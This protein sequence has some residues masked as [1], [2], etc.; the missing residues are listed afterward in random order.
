MLD[1]TDTFR[2]TNKGAAALPYDED[3]GTSSSL[4]WF[5][6]GEEEST[7]NGCKEIFRMDSAP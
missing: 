4:Y 5:E 7:L 2:V 6:Y 1:E 3:T